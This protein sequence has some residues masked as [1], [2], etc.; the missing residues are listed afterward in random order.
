MKEPPKDAISETE[1][2]VMAT[3]WKRKLEDHRHLE[4][5]IAEVDELGLRKV[6]HNK[7][8]AMSNIVKPSNTKATYFTENI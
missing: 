8:P 6:V 5:S 1:A 3:R 2:I 7:T 4:S